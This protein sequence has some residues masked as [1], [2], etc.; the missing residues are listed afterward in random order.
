VV[1]GFYCRLGRF[2]VFGEVSVRIRQAEKT[3]LRTLAGIFAASSED[4]IRRYRPDQAELLPVNSDGAVAAYG[5]LHRT[6]VMFVAEEPDPVGFSAAVVRDD[7]WFLS[8]LWV[9]PGRQGLGIGSALMDETLAWGHGASAFSVVSSPHPAAQTL[10]VRRSMY[11]LWMQVDLAGDAGDSHEVRDLPDTYAPLSEEDQTWVDEID[12]DVRGIARPVDH[13]FWRETATGIALRRAGSA[14]GYVYVWPPGG[15]T[16]KPKSK[17]GPG[18]VRDPRDMSPLLDAALRLA[19]GE[20]TVAVP[21]TN[22]SALNELVGLGF[23]ISIMNTFMAS[24][25]LPD[26]HRYISSGGSLA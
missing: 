11:P 20:V 5:H 2:L 19:G 4:L 10:Y 21:S 8:Q 7:V 18:A 24:R 1:H 14:V 25:A 6:G 3:D 23:R 16:A 22:W 15:W 17:I 13:A 26:G 12:R 9:V